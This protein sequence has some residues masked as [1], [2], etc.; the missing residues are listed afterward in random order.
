[1]IGTIVVLKY[2]YFRDIAEPDIYEM[3][4]V[5]TV[6]GP[7]DSQDAEIHNPIAVSYMMSYLNICTHTIYGI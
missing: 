2:P 6:V 5:H 4:T 1:M 7:T 3:P